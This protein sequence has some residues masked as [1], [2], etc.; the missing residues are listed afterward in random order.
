M[1]KDATKKTRFLCSFCSLGNARQFIIPCR[2]VVVRN[3]ENLKSLDLSRVE[4]F[5]REEL[6]PALPPLLRLKQNYITTYQKCSSYVVH[7]V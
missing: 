5:A 7:V 3:E 2:K 1:F 6:N 4:R